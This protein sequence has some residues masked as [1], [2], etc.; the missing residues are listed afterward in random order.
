MKAWV[1]GVIGASLVGGL[2]TVLGLAYVEHRAPDVVGPPPAATVLNPAVELPLPEKPNIVFV[3]TDDMT[4]YDLRWMPKTKFLLRRQGISFGDAISPHPLCCP[5]RAELLTGQFAQNNHV[6][7]NAGQRG[8]YAAF[9][10]AGSIG[11]WMQEAGYQTG[12]VGKHLNNYQ[13]RD[14][15]DPGWT[16]WDPLVLGIYDYFDYTFY[17]DNDLRHESFRG[18]YVTRSIE[19]RTNAAIRSFAL[20]SKPFMLYSWHLAPHY[21]RTKTSRHL[22]PPSAR[23][24]RDKFLKTRLPALDKSSFN[25]DDVRDQP[26]VLATREKVSRKSMTTHFR[27]RIRS[28]QAVDR[29]VA[30]MI[31]TLRE[32]GE[33]DNTYIV[34]TSD[35]GYSLGEHR[36]FGKNVLTQEV[37]QVPLLVRGPG[38]EP[39]T[40]SQLPSSLVDLP[41]TFAE[42]GGADPMLA[43]DGT[44][45]LGTLLDQG[46]SFRDT[47][48]VQTGR[49]TGD[50]WAYRGV[51]TERYLFGVHTA[52]GVPFLYDDRLD[53]DQVRNVATRPRYK[54][55]VKELRRRYA[56]LEDCSGA[57]CNRVFGPIPDP[58]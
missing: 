42:M 20:S 43:Q 6:L 16:L 38:I 19:T 33:L 14:G 11:A 53:P 28:L 45:L 23:Q 5:A 10:P 21:R 9:N 31:D 54:L 7:H 24:D 47:T 36:F 1:Q 52:T 46:Q 2:L 58:A 17:D 15:R 57:D 30:S 29:A 55:V 13:A 27:A 51:R 50:G 37:L 25:E 48:L 34:F 56:V 41:A 8:G 3:L 18:S 39:G 26:S 32:T 40:R 22:P 4:S 49:D 12:L 35:N 44:S